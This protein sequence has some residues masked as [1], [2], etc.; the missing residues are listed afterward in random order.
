MQLRLTRRAL[1]DLGLEVDTNAGALARDL[2]GLHPLIAAFVE[3]RGLH[4]EGQEAIQ[5]PVSRAT[6]HSL[7]AGR[8]RGLTWWERDGDTV[9]L[10]GAGYHRSGEREDVYAVLKHRDQADNLF[11][12]EQDYLDLEA[13]PAEFV[14]RLAEDAPRLLAAAHADVGEEIVGEIAG[15]LEVGVLV[16]LI[17]D[18]GERLQE[19]WLS[20]RMPP[21][22]DVPPYPEWLNAAIAA[23]LPEAEAVDLE[24]GAPFPRPSGPIRNEIV[25]RVAR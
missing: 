13:D 18:G 23:L 9:W 7:H 21:K 4:P 12:T 22:A 17:E 20:F 14:Q 2:V 10:L 16:I 11:P 3:R 24:F 8:W 5:L 15:A 25:V 1:D 19:T 6:V